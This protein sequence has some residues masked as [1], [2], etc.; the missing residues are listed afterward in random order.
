MTHITAQSVSGYI[1]EVLLEP[2]INQHSVE[3]MSNSQS[4]FQAVP[5]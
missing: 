5:L 3:N 1:F 2:E 4:L